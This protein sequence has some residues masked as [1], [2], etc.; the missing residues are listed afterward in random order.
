MQNNCQWKWP[1]NDWGSWNPPRTIGCRYQ[2]EVCNLIIS[3]ISLCLLVVFY[4]G[5]TI[6][7]AKCSAT[8]LC[9][10][11]EEA[12]ALVL[13]SQFL[14]R[15]KIYDWIYIWFW[16]V[17]G[18]YMEIIVVSHIVL[19]EKKVETRKIYARL[20]KYCSFRAISR[21]RILNGNPV[22][23]QTWNDHNISYSQWESSRVIF[24]TYKLAV[25]TTKWLQFYEFW[26]SMWLCYSSSVVY[27][28]YS[29]RCIITCTI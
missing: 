14:W 5:L 15:E 21:C 28:V 10:Q 4:S 17:G 20:E 26:K 6:C 27:F 11:F 23:Y 22:C 13:F 12:L 18:F 8:K 24:G 2:Q 1:Q 29:A 16:V 3:L 7:F 19:K 9:S 25:K